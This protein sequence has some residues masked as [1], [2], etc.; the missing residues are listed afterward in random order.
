MP[1]RNPPAL[2]EAVLT[3]WQKIKAGQR[4]ADIQSMRGLLSFDTFEKT[5]MGHLG[6]LGTVTAQKP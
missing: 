2:A 3:W 4:L 1:I 5:I 6:S